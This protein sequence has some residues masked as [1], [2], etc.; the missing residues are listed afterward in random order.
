MDKKAFTPTQ[1]NA[2]ALLDR[3]IG[4]GKPFA[5]AAKITRRTFSL[6]ERSHAAVIAAYDARP[7]NAAYKTLREALEALHTAILQCHA[8]LLSTPAY[9]K[10]LHAAKDA[11]HAYD[12]AVREFLGE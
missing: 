4:E 6:S 5:E 7:L 11:Q 10:A 2:L 3:L 9:I 12:V 8:G 1:L